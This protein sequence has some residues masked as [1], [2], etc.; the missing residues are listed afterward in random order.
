[1]K[2]PEQKYPEGTNGNISDDMLAQEGRRLMEKA[3]E[4]GATGL[5]RE[6]LISLALDLRSG[7]LVTCREFLSLSNKKRRRGRRWYK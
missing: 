2:I 7:E 4:Y 5:T 1:M 6:S 3:W